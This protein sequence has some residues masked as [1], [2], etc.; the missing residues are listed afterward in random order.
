MH[1][2]Q[3]DSINGFAQKQTYI[4]HI[5]LPH[6]GVCTTA[7][8]PQGSLAGE[9]FCENEGFTVSISFHPA[10]AKRADRDHCHTARHTDASWQ[11]FPSFLFLK[12]VGQSWVF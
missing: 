9:S 8:P 11:I 5:P 4:A 1:R 2:Q 12:G 6:L 10:Q 3:S 7:V